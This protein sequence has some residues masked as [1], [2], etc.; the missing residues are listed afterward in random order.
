MNRLLATL[1]T[2]FALLAVA[3]APPQDVDMVVYEVAVAIVWLGY[4]STGAAVLAVSAK[5]I[6]A[7]F[8]R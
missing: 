7:R 2:H 3:M 4:F 8:A 1:L 6:Y 5:T